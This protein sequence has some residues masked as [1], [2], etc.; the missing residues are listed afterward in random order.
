MY[1]QN[2][3]DTQ[4]FNQDCNLF[5]SHA[6]SHSPFEALDNKLHHLPGPGDVEIIFGGMLSIC[7]SAPNPNLLLQGHLVKLLVE[8]HSERYIAFKYTLFAC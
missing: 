1:S 7:Y 8:K 3:P 6:I 2:H 5:L 4:V